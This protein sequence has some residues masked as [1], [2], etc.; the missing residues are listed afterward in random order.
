MPPRQIETK[1]MT[2]WLHSRIMARETAHVKKAVEVLTEV[3]DKLATEGPAYTGASSGREERGMFPI[4]PSH[5]AYGL[6]IGNEPGDS[7]WQLGQTPRRKGEPVRV[8]LKNPMWKPYLQ[9]V[10]RGIVPGQKAPAGFVRDM[11]WGVVRKRYG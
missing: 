3:R 2:E 6:N 1:K 11:W 5:P 7:G 4:K 8:Y 10:D 9:F